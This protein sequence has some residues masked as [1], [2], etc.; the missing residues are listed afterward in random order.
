MMTVED[1][2]LAR[3]AGPPPYHAEK[4]GCWWMVL[5]GS[6]RNVAVNDTDA[7]SMGADQALAEAVARYLTENHAMARSV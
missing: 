1:W 4:V 5:D 3:H 7:A 6:G 2:K